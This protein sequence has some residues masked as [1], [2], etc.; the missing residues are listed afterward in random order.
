MSV[1]VAVCV[2]AG[3][4]SIIFVESVSVEV[5]FMNK[6]PPTNESNTSAPT[7]MPF[8]T[9]LF[10]A[11]STGGGLTLSTVLEEVVW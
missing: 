10:L 9:A 8:E 4:S 2:S 1:L 5:P 3:L 11:L 6:T 7:T